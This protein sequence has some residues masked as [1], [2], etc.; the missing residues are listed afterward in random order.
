[1]EPS[2]CKFRDVIRVGLVSGWPG[3]VIYYTTDGSV[4]GTCSYAG[5]GTS[6]LYLTVYTTCQVKAICVNSEGISSIVCSSDFQAEDTDASIGHDI[7]KSVPQQGQ[8][9]LVGVGVLFGRDTV[10]GTIVVKRIVPNGP[11]AKDVR[12]RLGQVLVSVNDNDVSILSIDQVMDLIIGLPGTLVTLRLRDLPSDGCEANPYGFNAILECN[13]IEIRRPDE[14]AR[15]QTS[16]G[17][18]DSRQQD[19]SDAKF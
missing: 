6:P 8:N 9:R 13:P 11:A 17:T 2:S 7:V 16:K 5:S 12:I 1:M 3:C 15:H 19:P 18:R 4:P 14:I 10:E